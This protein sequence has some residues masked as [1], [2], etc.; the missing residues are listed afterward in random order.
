MSVD[1]IEEDESKLVPSEEM[2]SSNE[3]KNDE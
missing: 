1:E 2:D 3:N